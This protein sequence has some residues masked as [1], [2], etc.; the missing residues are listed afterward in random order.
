MEL[1]GTKIILRDKK[2]EDATQDYAWRSDLE[3]AR[4][5]AT[6][7]LTMTSDRFLKIYQNQLRYPTPGSHHF[8]IETDDGTFIGNCMYYDLDR[9]SMEAEIGIVIGSRLYW[10]NSY[11]SDALIT[12]LD[13]LFT[14]KELR[15]VYL[16]TLEWNIRAQ[17]C[18]AK[19][20]FT[21]VKLVHRL[22]HDFI[23]MELRNEAWFKRTKALVAA[24]TNTQGQKARVAVPQIE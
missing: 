11:G 5:D 4:L 18:F 12:L 14:T 20:G 23:L 17:R 19:C 8:A 9:I 22:S 13:Y 15:R 2:L 21:P 16:H 24:R 1:P 3:L 6:Y 10:G 7:P